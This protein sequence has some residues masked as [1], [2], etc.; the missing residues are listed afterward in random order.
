MGNDT[1]F[2]WTTWLNC[3]FLHY[4]EVTVGP[5]VKMK[6]PLCGANILDGPGGV[7]HYVTI[8]DINSK[9]E[10]DSHKIVHSKQK[11]NSRGK[12]AFD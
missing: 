3:R 4:E 10:C 2:K 7:C 6:L 12:T 1:A 9:E 11:K 5:G 8:Y